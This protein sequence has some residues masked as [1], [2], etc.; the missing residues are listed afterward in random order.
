MIQGVIG[1]LVWAFEGM[2]KYVVLIFAVLMQM[3]LGGTYAWT[4]FAAGFS[5]QFGV[6]PDWAVMPF[7]TFYISFPLTMV[8]GGKLIAKLGTRA[9]AMLGGALFGIGWLVASLGA[10]GFWWTVVG[11][12]VVGGVGVGL[13]YVAPI[14]VG[15][16]WWPQ[17]RGL[18]TGLAVGG[19]AAG[20]ALVSQ[21]ADVRIGAGA[22]PF[23][24]LRLCG[25]AYLGI[26]LIAGFF[27]RMPESET[28]GRST[29][30]P[31]AAPSLGAL[32]RTPAFVA[33]FAAMTVG[34]MAGFFVNSNLKQFSSAEGLRLIMSGAAV[35]AIANAV[36]RIVWGLVSDYASIAGVIRVNLMSQAVVLALA[37]YLVTSGS[38]M[39]LF[40]AVTGF[41][42][43]GV[44]VLYAATVGRVWGN[45]AIAPVYGKLFAANIL[46]SVL[47]KA[48]T[49]LYN[50]DGALGVAGWTT[51]VALGVVAVVA[52][53]WLTFPEQGASAS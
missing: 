53:R 29:A 23:E 1:S 38:G 19:F 9:S 25:G 22:S 41:N 30:K 40:A 45:D 27:M 12:G 36:G 6:S 16:A 51:A 20:A 28:T 31:Q 44:L 49:S 8:L 50:I 46:A 11:A 39:L 21:V 4:V 24:V 13:A 3:C 14:A 43:G 5:D 33:L 32:V 17:R 47:S 15:V 18:V 10:A 42:Y 52:M 26:A 7:N 37:P 35:F 2:R 48:L 34:L